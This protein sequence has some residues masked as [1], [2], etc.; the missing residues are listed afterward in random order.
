MKTGS[1]AKQKEK[2]KFAALTQENWASVGS[3][4]GAFEN[5]KLIQIENSKKQI[6]QRKTKEVVKGGNYANNI[7]FNNS[8]ISMGD[9][10]D[11]IM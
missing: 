1:A 5:Q 8:L 4:I 7:V 6:Q 2:M 9:D 3:T 11:L 10:E